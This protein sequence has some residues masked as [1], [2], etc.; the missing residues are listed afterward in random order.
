MSK[1][2]QPR[3]IIPQELYVKRDADRQLTEILNDMGRPGYV[4]VSRQ[5]GKTNLILNA[6]REHEKEGDIFVYIDLSNDF[7]NER[8]CFENIIDTIIET[9]SEKLPNIMEKIGIIRENPND[10]PAHKLH[11]KE[12]RTI[13]QVLPGKLVII[14]DEIDALTKIDYS[15]KIFSQIRSVYFTR[16]N[17][18]EFERLTY[19]LSGVVEPTE[20]IKNSK[21]SPFNIGQKIFLNDFSYEEFLIFLKRSELVF[22]EEVKNELF[23]WTNGSPRILWDICSELE[24]YE[25]E[26]ITVH[27]L[28]EIIDQL[29]LTTFDR[30]PIDSIR[31]LVKSDPEIQ[32]AIVEI[33]YGNGDK[34]SDRL[35]SKLYLAGIIN[36]KSG[37][38]DIKNEIIMQSISLGW[39]EEIKRES[40]SQFALGCEYF[41]KNQFAK[42]IDAFNALLSSD[43]VL[44]EEERFLTYYHLGAASF[45]KGKHQAAIDFIDKANLDIEDNSRLFYIANNIKALSFY[46][47]GKIEDSLRTY[48]ISLERN[49]KDEIF[50]AALVNF[51]AISIRSNNK[52][53]V[54]EAEDI[55]LS[56][57]DGS[58]LNAEKISQEFFHEIKTISH[59]N[60]ALIKDQTHGECEEIDRNISLA[61]KF[62]SNR[63]KPAVI[64][65][66]VPLMKSVEEKRKTISPLVKQIVIGK[67]EPKQFLP[68]KPLE[69]SVEHFIELLV[70]L[71][72][73]DFSDLFEELKTKVHFLGRNDYASNLIELA[74]ATMKVNIDFSKLILKEAIAIS[75]LGESQEEKIAFYNS[76]KEFLKLATSKEFIEAYF[77]F[78]ELILTNK[79]IVLDKR[80]LNI[81]VTLINFLFKDR[82]FKIALSFIEQIIS[83]KDRTSSEYLS[84]FIFI[85]NFELIISQIISNSKKIF[86]SA[87]NIIG[88]TEQEKSW[89]VFEMNEKMTISEIRKTTELIL[90][91]DSFYGELSRNDKVKVYYLDK[92]IKTTKY[93]KVQ[94]D[95][96]SKECFLL[97][98]N[99]I[100]ITTLLTKRM[101]AKKL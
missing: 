40:K 14:L 33:E 60:L 48:K 57:A 68:D 96:E 15:D 63:L 55:F 100:P 42:A 85:H 61:L 27:L 81:L 31:T 1:K 39:L 34:I 5:M 98:V 43:Q 65:G 37:Q 83:F 44:S 13:L 80:D 59:L 79:D 18:P 4:L 20:I 28:S 89:E 17:Y 25:E 76:L 38:V 74:A 26:S 52:N 99:D 46:Y 10:L 82:K 58:G 91:T 21:I 62:V 78:F 53:Y 41:Q 92:K 95:I 12:L 6:K 8:L 94:D 7:E 87:I 47:L 32:N 101:A 84:Y 30:P 19:I 90:N 11:V 54:Q 97:E 16:V 67:I 29:Y 75:K 93:K 45:Q 86:N 72:N 35:K 49:K 3:T 22:S 23:R 77:E 66:V 24:N 70:F 2:L 50:A 51:G 56:I 71:F 88:I 64:L 36:Q 9:S 73:E 69:F